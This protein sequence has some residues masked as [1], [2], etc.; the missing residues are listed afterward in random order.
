MRVLRRLAALGALLALAAPVSAAND[1]LQI[2]V[3]A[4]L[5][6]PGAFIGKQDVLTL[7][8]LE[9]MVN[10][11][12]GIRGRPIHF[13]FLDDQT[14]PQVTVQLVN[15]VIA[16][17]APLIMGPTIT[18]TC[19]ASVPLVTNGPLLYCLTPGVTP[20]KGGYAFSTS[21][22]TG[23]LIVKTFEFFRKRGWRR[24]ATLTTIDATGQDA[25]DHFSE[26]LALP[27]NK[28]T[29][30]VARQHFTNSDVSLAAQI[31]RIRAAKPDV[32]IA[33]T[34]GPSI[35]TVFQNLVQAGYD[36]PVLTTNANQTHLQ[37]SQYRDILPKELYF[38]G[39]IFVTGEMQRKNAAALRAFYDA[40]KEMGVKPDLQVGFAWD[41]ALIII[42]AL[43][44]LGPS[45]TSEQIRNY[46]EQL[47]GFAGING[48][49]D[50][51][52]G[53]NRGLGIGDAFIVKWDAARD[54]WLRQ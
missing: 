14:N 42:D 28:G 17:G 9:K 19:R 3:V 46:I 23:D 18:A 41:P 1:T 24:I 13:E 2:D 26:A 29:E 4:A 53:S 52:D 45:P 31:A 33:W 39:V 5:T 38:P 7:G 32:L 10:R 34:T 44:H 48:I 27:A 20:P 36:V 6:G 49:Y 40:C 12:G 25:D 15:G 50:F 51:R 22:S 21:I 35:G 47:H 30:I 43:R 37:M 54:T 11:E 8:Q 16:K